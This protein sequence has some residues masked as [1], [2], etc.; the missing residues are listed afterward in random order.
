MSISVAGRPIQNS[1]ALS[2][3]GRL[4][5]AFVDGGPQWLNWAIASLGT[6]YHFPDE[7]TLLEGTQ[8]GLHGSPWRCCPAWGCRSAPS[9]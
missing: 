3:L 7:A 2:E 9:S 5:L 1:S 6:H 8:K 4:A